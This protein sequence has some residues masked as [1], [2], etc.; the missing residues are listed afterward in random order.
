MGITLQQLRY[1]TAVAEEG[2]LTLAA[3]KL[4]VTQPVLSRALALLQQELSAPIFK[5]QS[6]KL[7]LTLEGEAALIPARRALAAVE[8]VKRS[9]IHKQAPLL[10]IAAQSTMLA[11]IAPT[12]ARVLRLYPSMHVSLATAESIDAMSEMLGSDQ[13]DF[14]FGERPSSMGE[15]RWVPWGTLEVVLVSPPDI[16]LPDEVEM[17]DQAD[18]PLIATH[19]STRRYRSFDDLFLRA[20][21][22][23][24]IVVESEDISILAPFV[25][26]GVGSFHAWRF[27]A[28]TLP[29]VTVRRFSP[30]RTVEIGFTYIDR[31]QAR[32]RQF[33]DMALKQ[34]RPEYL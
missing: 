25:A 27:V 2:S 10:N 20:G 34:H 16:D 4:G 9:A 14:V 22:R 32:V 15:A 12:F 8:E 18:L 6:R 11:L 33:I 23:P 17:H 1:L 24:K 28:E 29:G 30:R 5:R 13:I 26:A 19:A 31:R 21:V 3:R 7:V